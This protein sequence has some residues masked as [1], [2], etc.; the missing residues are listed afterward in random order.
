[1]SAT[2]NNQQ[3]PQNQN[4]PQDSAYSKFVKSALLSN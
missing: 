1:M 2:T 4:Q 3:V